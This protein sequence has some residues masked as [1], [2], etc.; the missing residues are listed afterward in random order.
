MFSNPQVTEKMDGIAIAALIDLC[1]TK[2]IPTEELRPALETLYKSK[3]HLSSY[4]T[5][6]DWTPNRELR[7]LFEKLLITPDFGKGTFFEIVSNYAE[8]EVTIRRNPSANPEILYKRKRNT[9][10][11]T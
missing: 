5:R 10:P 8:E 2:N 1:K 4:V 9:E 3:N 7:E 11:T 6:I